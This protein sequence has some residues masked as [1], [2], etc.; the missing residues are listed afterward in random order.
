MASGTKPLAR[1]SAAEVRRL[2]LKEVVIGD[3]DCH[4]RRSDKECEASRFGAADELAN[5]MSPFRE[6][7]CG[8]CGRGHSQFGVFVQ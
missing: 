3:V 8:R 4:G 1:W 6:M 5:Q 7:S 2:G